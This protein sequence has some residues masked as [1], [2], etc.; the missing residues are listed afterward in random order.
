MEKKKKIQ[1][2]FL[3]KT[4]EKYQAIGREY[5]FSEWV[6][7]GKNQKLTNALNSPKMKMES[8]NG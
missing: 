7:E 6:I 8:P 3:C 4:K 1:P 2:F 5:D